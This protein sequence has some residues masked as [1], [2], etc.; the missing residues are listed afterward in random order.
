MNNLAIIGGIGCGVIVIEVET[1]FLL[2]SSFF[3]N[4]KVTDKAYSLTYL[5]RAFESTCIGEVLS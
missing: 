5:I 4:P 1:S 2:S 3:A